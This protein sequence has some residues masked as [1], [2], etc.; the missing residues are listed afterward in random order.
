MVNRALPIEHQGD[1][2]TTVYSTSRNIA[3][4]ML[5]V[6]VALFLRSKRQQQQQLR[7]NGATRLT[8]SLSC[9]R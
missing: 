5:A 1:K 7:Y 2:L 9:C 4:G 8:P 6:L 3:R